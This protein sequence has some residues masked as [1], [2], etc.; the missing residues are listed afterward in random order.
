MTK[1]I[2]RHP[3]MFVGACTLPYILFGLPSYHS[4]H[5][6]L[7]IL[8]YVLLSLLFTYFYFNWNVDEAELNEALN[9]EIEK[10]ELSKQQLWAYTGL[11]VYTVT[12]DE[13]E[14]YTFF[15]NKADKK[16]LL[17]KLKAYNQ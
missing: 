13:Q 4:Q 3:W 6:W 9:K 2:E 17:N 15:M 11:N 16:R 1:K 10:T 8:I 7:K 14:G 12:P 5:A